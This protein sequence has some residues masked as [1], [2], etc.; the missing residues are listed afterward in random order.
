MRTPLGAQYTTTE[1]VSH[2]HPTLGSSLPGT[3]ERGSEERWSIRSKELSY[4]AAIIFLECIVRIFI[5]P[6]KTQ[7]YFDPAFL[8][9]TLRNMYQML[10]KVLLER[11]KIKITQV[12]NPKSMVTYILVYE[13]M[14]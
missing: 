4:T 9:R 12:L 11:L 1:S 3:T 5:K 14:R 7:I 8:F 6:L 13:S 10:S 2:W